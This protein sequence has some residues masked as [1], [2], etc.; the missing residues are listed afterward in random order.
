MAKN[1]G[2]WRVPPGWDDAKSTMS[3]SQKLWR[4]KDEEITLS[5]WMA[6]DRLEKYATL[7]LVHRGPND[8]VDKFL[9]ASTYASPK[10][11]KALENGPENEHSTTE[12]LVLILVAV[13]IGK[14][15]ASLW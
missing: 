15:V 3:V 5:K 9:W 12:L 7:E 10:R 6:K 11:Q 14:L 4:T 1:Y 13:E 8:V 2:Q